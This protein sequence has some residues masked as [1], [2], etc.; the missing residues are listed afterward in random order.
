MNVLFH[1]SLAVLTLGLTF[2][3]WHADELRSVRLVSF[4]GLLL[5]VLVIMMG[6]VW[7]SLHTLMGLLAIPGTLVLVTMVLVP[8]FVVHRRIPRILAVSALICA[9]AS[10]SSQAVWNYQCHTL[11]FVIPNDFVGDIY[12]IQDS[13]A[14]MDLRKERYTVIFPP[15]GTVR[16]L[17]D[18]FMFRCYS[19]EAR[20]ESGE[21]AILIDRGATGRLERQWARL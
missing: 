21:P 5:L 6:L 4:T 9:A 17:D 7:P 16:I 8:K 11:R 1:G 13:K 14:G 10:F 3:V 2:A 18:D 20:Y 12:L 15:S 19:M